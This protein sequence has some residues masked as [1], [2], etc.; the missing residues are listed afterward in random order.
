MCFHHRRAL[1]SQIV[2]MTATSES[3]AAIVQSMPPT[4]STAVPVALSARDPPGGCPTVPATPTARPVLCFQHCLREV[5]LLCLQL[6]ATCPLCDKTVDRNRLLLSPSV[7]P[8]PFGPASASPCSVVIK[9]SKGSFLTSLTT[10]LDLHVG[11]TDSRGIVHE[12]DRRGLTVGAGDWRQCVTIPLSCGPNQSK[13]VDSNF[14]D[15]TLEV[16]ENRQ[17][18]SRECY[19][20]EDHNCFTFVLDFVRTLQLPGLSAVALNRTHFCQQ[21]IC[22]RMKSVARYVTLYR[23]LEAD[24]IYV[25]KIV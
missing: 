21:V 9:P 1:I 18:W 20:G 17:C 23:K 2:T 8:S 3:P 22:P 19:D 10:S 14:W 24:H 11:L 25:K 13:A 7:I 5:H 16:T 6:P 15:Y 4:I 12:Y